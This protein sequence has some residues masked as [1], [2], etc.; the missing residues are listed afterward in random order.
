LCERVLSRETQGSVL[1]QKQ[2]IQG[3]IADSYAELAQFRLLVLYTAWEIDQ[4]KDYRRTR[5]NIAAIKALTPKVVHDAVWRSMHAHGALGVSNEMPFGGMWMMA[6]IMSVVDGPTEVHK[7]TVAREVLKGYQPSPGL[8]P[9]AHLPAKREEARQ[10][11][12][13]TSS[14]SSATPRHDRA[15]RSLPRVRAAL[16]R[17]RG[18]GARPGGRARAQVVVE[19]RPPRSTSPTSCW[20]PISTRSTFPCRSR[21]AVSSPAPCGRGD[22]RRRRRGG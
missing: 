14:T 18:G 21:W 6:P 4:Y 22:R 3:D 2:F 11:L 20:W 7:V 9:T 13:A 8:W 12:A 17:R 15:R 16:I 19:W 5:K 1:A 10:K